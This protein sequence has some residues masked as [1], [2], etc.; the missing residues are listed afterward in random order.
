[1]SCELGSWTSQG[2]L[3]PTHCYPGVWNTQARC[4]VFWS[5]LAPRGET[6]YR[7]IDFLIMGEQ[8]WTIGAHPQREVAIYCLLFLFMSFYLLFPVIRTERKSIYASLFCHCCIR[9]LRKIYFSYILRILQSPS[10]GPKSQEKSSVVVGRETNKRPCT[11][12]VYSYGSIVG[13]HP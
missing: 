4:W 2:I 1:M 5:S 6:L 7:W 8:C 11:C 10:L 9:K 13:E 12:R 3:N